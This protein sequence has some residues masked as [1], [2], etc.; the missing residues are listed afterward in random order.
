MY[1]YLATFESFCQQYYGKLYEVGYNK[2]FDSRAYDHILDLYNIGGEERLWKPEREFLKSGGKSGEAIRYG[3]S[4]ELLDLY[5]SAFDYLEG[6]GIPWKLISTSIRDFGIAYGIKVQY[7][8]RV[9]ADLEDIFD[10][11][12]ENNTILNYVEPY[13]NGEIIVWLLNPEE[14]EFDYIDPQFL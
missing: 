7:S 6:R 14:D 11:A 12:P 2:E 5:N 1:R 13:G 8:P 10:S 9:E 4:Q 3:F